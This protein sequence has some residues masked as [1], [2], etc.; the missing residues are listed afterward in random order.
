MLQLYAENMNQS[1]MI[2]TYAMRAGF[3]G[4]VVVDWPHRYT[5]ETT[6]NDVFHMS[7]L[8]ALTICS[9]NL[10]KVVL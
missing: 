8:Y 7:K 9:T 1:E 10:F 2:M 3:A 4:G 6:T 5:E